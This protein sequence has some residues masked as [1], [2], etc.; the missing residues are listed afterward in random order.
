M[1]SLDGYVVS[2]HVGCGGAFQADS[3]WFRRDKRTEAHPG[4]TFE[5][6]TSTISQDDQL[7]PRPLLRPL[8]RNLRKRPSLYVTDHDLHCVVTAGLAGGT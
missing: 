3:P 5:S 2:R 8:R 6:L 4:S 7:F 1:F